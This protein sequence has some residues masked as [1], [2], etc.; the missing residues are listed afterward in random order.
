L[1][2]HARMCMCKTICEQQSQEDL[3]MTVTTPLRKAIFAYLIGCLYM[4]M[5][6]RVL[7]L[8][9]FEVSCTKHIQHVSTN[10]SYRI[11]SPRVCAW[12]A[13]AK[14]WLICR[15]SRTC[16]CL[17]TVLNLYT[18]LCRTIPVVSNAFPCANSSNFWM[19]TVQHIIS[20]MFSA[21]FLR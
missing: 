2:T 5:R 19:Q 16:L 18:T 3:W 4:C 17:S 8:S 9:R 14:S 1:N 21:S 10:H 12:A 7:F 20:N 6:C 15:R 13:S 11:A